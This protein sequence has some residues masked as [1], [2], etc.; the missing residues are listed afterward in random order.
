MFKDFDT[1]GQMTALHTGKVVSMQEMPGGHTTGKEQARLLVK[2]TVSL[3]Y[4]LQLHAPSHVEGLLWARHI[5]M[6]VSQFSRE[7]RTITI[8]T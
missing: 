4:S 6:W 8:E 1:E 5:L 7:F 3:A 2:I